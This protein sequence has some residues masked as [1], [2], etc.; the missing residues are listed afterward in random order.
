M[1]SLSATTPKRAGLDPRDVVAYRRFAWRAIFSCLLHETFD[2]V[3]EA[4]Q[5]FSEAEKAYPRSTSRLLHIFQTQTS[6][7][8]GSSKQRSFLGER[9]VTPTSVFASHQMDLWDEI[10]TPADLLHQPIPS[11]PAELFEVLEHHSSI[12]MWQRLSLSLDGVTS[13]TSKPKAIYPLKP[14]NAD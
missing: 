11:R 12:F 4:W 8:A 14:Q 7:L 3:K 6:T 1:H 13:P 5:F 9:S 2:R 10:D